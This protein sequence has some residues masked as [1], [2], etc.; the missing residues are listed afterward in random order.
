MVTV[1]LGDMRRDEDSIKISI[2]TDFMEQN[3]EDL[4]KIQIISVLSW[5]LNFIMRIL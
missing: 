5:N 3:F 4:T 1:D 2:I